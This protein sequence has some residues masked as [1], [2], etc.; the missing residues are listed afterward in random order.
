METKF[1]VEWETP[2]GQQRRSVAM[3]KAKAEA[4]A[5]GL[6]HFGNEPEMVT[7]VEMLPVKPTARWQRVKWF[8]GDLLRGLA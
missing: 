3:A 1:V 8:V 6:I 7:L 4:F 5:A 2:G